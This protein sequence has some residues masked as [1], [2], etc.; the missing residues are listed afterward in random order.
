[1]SDEATVRVYSAVYHDDGDEL[2]GVFRTIEQAVDA[3]KQH[4][5]A[6]RYDWKSIDRWEIAEACSDGLTLRGKW[7]PTREGIPGICLQD[8]IVTIKA[9]DV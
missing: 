4:Q 8:F 5:A 1:V 9:H 7:K 2:V 3:C 6:N